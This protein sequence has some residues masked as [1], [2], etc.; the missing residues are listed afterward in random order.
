MRLRFCIRGEEK[1]RLKSY[2]SRKESPYVDEA[3]ADT[4]LSV[5]QR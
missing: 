5:V 3:K 4:D 2:K 1:G